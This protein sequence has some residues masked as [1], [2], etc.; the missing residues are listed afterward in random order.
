MGE[1][2]IGVILSGGGST[3]FGEPKAFAEMNGKPFYQHAADALSPYTEEILVV[4]HPDLKDRFENETAYSVIQD[5][6][7]FIEKGPLSGIYTA[8]QQRDAQWYFVLA[9]D[10]PFFNAEAAGKLFR[11]LSSGIQ[12]VIPCSDNRLQPLCAIYHRDTLL[13]LTNQLASGSYRMMEWI[14]RFHAKTVSEE[15][16]GIRKRAFENINDQLEFE[17][18]KKNE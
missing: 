1:K 13:H 2:C 14:E 11:Y 6:E 18:L 17:H 10:M 12:G 8:M 7:P 15:E 16:S 3:R 9:C 4:S 5:Q